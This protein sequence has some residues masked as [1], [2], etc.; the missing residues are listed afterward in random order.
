MNQLTAF[1]LLASVTCAY[2]WVPTSN[3]HIR[4]ASP[5]QLS[6]SPDPANPCWQDNYDSEDDCLSTTYSA[7]FVAEDWIKSMPCGKVRYATTYEL[8]LNP[9]SFCNLS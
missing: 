5:S 2:A 6:S 1:K 8:F 4:N 3:I 7:A 9:S